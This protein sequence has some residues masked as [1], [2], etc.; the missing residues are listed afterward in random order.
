METFALVIMRIYYAVNSTYSILPLLYSYRR[1]FLRYVTR[2]K[3]DNLPYKFTNSIF[4]ASI[5]VVR[6]IFSFLISFSRC[7]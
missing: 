6:I 7:S 4:N 1:Y 3:L 2:V 5:G